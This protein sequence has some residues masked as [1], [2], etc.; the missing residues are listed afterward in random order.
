M[1]GTPSLE[2]FQE[3]SQVQFVHFCSFDKHVLLQRSLKEASYRSSYRSP[4]KNLHPKRCAL[5]MHNEP[6][7]GG[8]TRY[9][10]VLSILRI[11]LVDSRTRDL[12]LGDREIEWRKSG[13][14]PLKSERG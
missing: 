7:I 10:S 13:D 9:Y 1:T 3:T 5:K 11:D 12:E 14:W 2:L 4:S 8:R 6:A